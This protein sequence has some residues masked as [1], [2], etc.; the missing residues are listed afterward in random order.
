LK[1]LRRKLF[2]DLES[3]DKILVWR[4][5]AT[6]QREQ[7]QPLLDVLRRL[8][9]NRL[10][11]VTNEDATHP[12]GSVEEL[13]PDFLKGYVR[14]LGTDRLLSDIEFEP[15]FEL[16]RNVE[17]LRQ[18]DRPVVREAAPPRAWAWFLAR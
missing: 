12:S 14:R 15:W 11:W 6:T 16:C 13:E 5:S 4:S 17:A 1:F 2:E 3:G 18:A 9:P 10:L 8:G 7:V